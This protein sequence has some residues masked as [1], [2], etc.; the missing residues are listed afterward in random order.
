MR[1]RDE[2]SM[3]D[4]WEVRG[5]RLSKKMR[6]RLPWP[7]VDIPS[8]VPEWQEKVGKEDMKKEKETK[9]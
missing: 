7:Q 5:M 6:F 3:S 9:Y 1:V 2:A 8:C 4:I